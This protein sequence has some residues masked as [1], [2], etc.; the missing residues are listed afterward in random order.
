MQLRSLHLSPSLKKQTNKQTKN[1]TISHKKLFLNFRK[2]NF[3]F[4]LERVFLMFLEMEVS[5]PKLRSLRRVWMLQQLLLFT[6]CSS[7]DFL[8]HLSPKRVSQITL[9]SLKLT[10][11]H[12]CNVQDTM[13]LLW[14]PSVSHLTLPRE[15]EDFFRGAK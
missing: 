2:W 8:I 5:S 9:G 1:I 14:S 15:A 12:L 11:L 7:I 3:L 6:G 4:F 13:P 10:A